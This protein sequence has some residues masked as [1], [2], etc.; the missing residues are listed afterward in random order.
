MKQKSNRKVVITSGYYNPLH[1]G[2]VN[3]IREAKNLGDF[4]VVI[5]NNDKQVEAKGSVPF[6][7]EGERVEII[8]AVKDV[9]EVFLSIDEDRTV[10][11]SLERVFQKHKGK[12]LLFAKGGD[13]TSE[14][15]PEMEV[16]EK[17]GAKI[18]FDVGGGKVQ[19]SSWLIEK[20]IKR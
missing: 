13:S 7:P 14:N 3:L 16:C 6:M 20:S 15:V 12:E 10:I 19:S 2:H 9:D 8:K 5:V 1:I 11:K 4:L 17:F 18:I